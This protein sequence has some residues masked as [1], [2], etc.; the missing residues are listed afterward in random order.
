[1]SII[2]GVSA[3][4]S[5]DD[6]VALGAVFSQLLGEG[7]VLA[8]VQPPTIEFPSIGNVDA[9]WTTYLNEQ[10]SSILAAA[11]E[12]L[13]AGWGINAVKSEIVA[14]ASVSRGL[15]DI[16]ERIDAS[17]I[18]V[19]PGGASEASRVALGST[20]QSLIH[21]AGVCVGLA[22]RSY[23]ANFVERIGRLV[24]GFRDT[25][26]GVSALRWSL[27]I[28]D[29][30]GVDVE[31]LTAIIRV[32]RIA[33]PRLGPDPERIILE[34]LREQ[35]IRAQQSAI[36]QVGRFVS[37]TVVEGDSAEQALASFTWRSDDLLV[38]GSSRYGAIS[39]VILGDVGKKLLRASTVPV[40]VLPRTA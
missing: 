7:L 25:D 32:T 9:E 1:M 22:P 33:N 37:G 4:P 13:A 31:L 29:G 6:A 17:A 19:G 5:S 3:D 15:L 40:L 30:A 21:G 36:D 14:N 2:V 16:A 23:A 34:V 10:A 24:V 39:R 35:E 27:G 38:L 18:V 11:R 12:R 26:P 20:A 28:A 8:H